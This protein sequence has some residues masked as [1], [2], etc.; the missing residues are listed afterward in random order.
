MA[1]IEID[2]WLEITACSVYFP[3]MSR[4]Q[5]RGAPNTQNEYI[6]PY[7]A[8]I[9]ISEKIHTIVLDMPLCLSNLICYK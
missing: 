1:N 2:I 9:K 6:L 8:K 7:L 5:G 4:E 3:N